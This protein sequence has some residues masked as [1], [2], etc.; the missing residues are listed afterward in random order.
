MNTK[1]I[2]QLTALREQIIQVTTEN[3]TNVI[4]IDTSTVLQLIENCLHY[5]MQLSI[6]YDNF[7]NNPTVI[8]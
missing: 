5:E 6:V 4:T 8:N 7:N 2:N 3:N 1:Y